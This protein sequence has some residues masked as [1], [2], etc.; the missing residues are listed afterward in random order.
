M[1]QIA[2]MRETVEL[3]RQHVTP[4]WSLRSATSLEHLESMLARA[5][6]G[7]DD[8]TPFPPSK[9]GRW[10]GWMQGCVY[11]MSEGAT[12]LN[13]FK[14]INRKHSSAKR[15]LDLVFQGTPPNARFVEA[16]IDGKS[17]RVGEWSGPDAFGLYTLK[18]RL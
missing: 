11:V 9:L 15:T 16:E 10:L 12:D 4:G 1:D 8:G 13:T 6:A 17:V 3:A 2:A 7:N 5:E 18:V 14:E